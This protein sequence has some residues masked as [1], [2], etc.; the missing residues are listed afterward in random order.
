[1]N[2]NI[3]TETF[4]KVGVVCFLII[5]CANVANLLYTWQLQNVFSIVASV[6][7][8]VFNFALVL[9]FYTLLR[10]TSGSVS[11]EERGDDVNE[12]IEKMKEAKTDGRK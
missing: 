5:G 12:L 9:M 11:Y 3:D 2:I 10:Q 6:G 7:G 1:M 8:I 4:F